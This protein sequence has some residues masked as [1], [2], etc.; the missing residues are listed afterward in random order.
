M[1]IKTNKKAQMKVQQMAFMLIGL[2]IFFVL[3]G[4]FALSFAFSGLKDSKALLDEK[5]ATLLVSKLANSPEFSCGGAFGTDKINCVDMD[6]VLALIEEIDNYDGFWGV[7]GIEII[8]IYPSSTGECT[9][10][11]Y[12]NCEL[13]TVLRSEKIGTDK[14]TFVSLC[15]KEK[16]GNSFYDKC[17]L[18][19]LIVRVSNEEVE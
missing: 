16:E 9:G 5:E 7:E 4:L 17:E 8:R 11:S 3:V 14:S 10:L 1:V 12:P 15:R 2:T 18:G 13:L 6:K 19:K